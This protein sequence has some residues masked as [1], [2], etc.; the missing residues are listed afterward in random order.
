MKCT[1]HD[2]LLHHLRPSR[3]SQLHGLVD[4]IDGSGDC[5]L[6]GGIEIGRLHDSCGACLTAYVF[7]HF[8][9]QPYDG[10]HG[11]FLHLTRLLHELTAEADEPEAILKTQGSGGDKCGILSKRVTCHHG[12][13]VVR[14]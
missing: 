6:S 4:T 9:G 13:N 7:G 14:H 1:A 10:R 3:L 11:A 12:R 5:D 8:G 2:Q